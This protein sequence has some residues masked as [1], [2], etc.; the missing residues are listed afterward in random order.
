MLG[1][2][3]PA[4]ETPCRWRFTGG[5][6]MTHLQGYLNPPT[7]DQLKKRSQSWTPSEKTFWIRAC[8]CLVIFIFAV[9]NS[10]TFKICFEEYHKTVKQC[11]SSQIKP[12]LK[13]KN[14]KKQQK[15]KTTNAKP[16]LGPN[17]LQALSADVNI[18]FDLIFRSWSIKPLFRLC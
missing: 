18:L 14:S 2:H 17:C 1:H 10:L 8:A 3:R 7:P 4:S 12:P 9:I 15:K 16:N 6:M 13:N 5:P 11:V